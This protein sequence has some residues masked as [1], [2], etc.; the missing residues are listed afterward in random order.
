MGA[1]AC[2]AGHSRVGAFVEFEVYEKV[3]WRE[4]T[5]AQAAAATDI[6]H[7]G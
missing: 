7:L 2:P 4:V 3:R 6:H 1:S 5:A